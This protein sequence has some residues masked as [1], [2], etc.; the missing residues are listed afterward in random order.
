MTR[1]LPIRYTAM[2]LGEN[3]ATKLLIL[4][5]FLIVIF[6]FFW[7]VTASIK[8]DK[9]IVT[10][11][12]FLIPPEVTF[13]HYITVFKYGHFAR[14]FLN[15]TIVSLSTVLLSLVVNIPAAYAI[16][17]LRVPGRTIISRF[18]LSLQMIPGILLV[19][20]LYIIL[21]NYHLLDTYYG[22]IIS[23]TTF[24]IPFSFLLAS[25]YFFRLPL[26]LFESAFIDGASTFTA[27]I[28]IAI[29]LSAPGLMT[30]S[31]YAFLNAWNDFVFAN[32][33]T[34]SENARTLTVE[35]TRLLGTW[36][37]QWGDLAAGATVTTLPVLIVF[38]LAHQYIVEGL[39]AGAVKG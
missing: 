37:T 10:T 31:V 30:T 6:P 11:K 33:F 23:Y 19:V 28:R 34:N 25:A 7:V 38:M 4:I 20:P 29:P 13:A 16:S 8:P 24:T 9:F 27:L 3:I 21:K 15:S 32:T 14:I 26:E 17:I 18:I 39:T 12:V 2:R 22:L 36:G 5:V 1:M 35:V